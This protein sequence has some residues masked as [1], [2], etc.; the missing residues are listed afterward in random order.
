LEK[1]F[2]IIFPGTNL[3]STGF[4][5][6]GILLGTGTGYWGIITTHRYYIM[7]EKKV[8]KPERFTAHNE[9]Q[10]LQICTNVQIYHNFRQSNFE[11]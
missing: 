8:P 6:G 7:F 10:D 2:K 9:H 11:N 3:T 5:R 1:K 4:L